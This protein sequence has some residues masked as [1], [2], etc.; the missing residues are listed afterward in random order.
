MAG[1][2]RFFYL[3]SSSHGIH[4]QD[5]FSLIPIVIEEPQFLVVNKPAGL[6]TQAVPGIESLSTKLA[7]QLKERD[8]HPGN[9]FV[10]LPHRLDRGTSGVV[11][12][13]KNQRALR[14][15]GDQFHHRLVQKFY[16]AWV[17]G[18][19]E[20]TTANWSDY[21]RKVPD[22]PR[23]ELVAA[24]C[25][26]AKLAEL[27]VLR[28]AVAGEQSLALVQLLT[29]RMHQIR[30]QFA[31]RVHCVIGDQLYGS[32]VALS[33]HPDSRLHPLGLH[34]FR[35][36]FRHP[37]TARPIAASAFLPEYWQQNIQLYHAGQ[38]WIERSLAEPGRNWVMDELAPI[39]NS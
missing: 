5:D 19:L 9:P 17:E 26:E 1:T 13:A 8:N 7:A 15:L 28:L 33:D 11:V 29:G 22:E 37:Q 21:L 14:R 25:P 34:A 23:A 2:P 27:R 12:I 39:R 4:Q 35:I 20:Q 38:A 10:G 3:V 32:S 30:L 36:E 18:Q 6:L 31:S 16:L 24:D